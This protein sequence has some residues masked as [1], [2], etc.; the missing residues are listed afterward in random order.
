MNVDRA[1]SV[2]PTFKSNIR[3]FPKVHNLKKEIRM[4]KDRSPVLVDFEGRNR[5]WNHVE[6]AEYIGSTPGSIRVM[7]S[8]R[9]IPFLKI[10]RRV[11]FSP[12]SIR[13]WLEEKRVEA[14]S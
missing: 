9:E 11:R 5:L 2:E 14:V 12:E 6:V 8:R 4:S 1:K 3:I 7:C 13:R 10:G